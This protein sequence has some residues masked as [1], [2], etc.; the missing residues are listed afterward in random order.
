MISN[1]TFEYLPLDIPPVATVNGQRPANR[2]AT[3]EE[4]NAVRARRGYTLDPGM[5]C[6]VTWEMFSSEFGTFQY[7]WEYGLLNGLKWFWMRLPSP[8]G[9]EAWCLVRF[10]DA[11]EMVPAGWD[12]N[13]VTARLELRDRFVRATRPYTVPAP[14]T[15][16]NLDDDPLWANVAFA[17]PFETATQLDDVKNGFTP[18]TV[19]GTVGLADG[20]GE[21]PARHA[22]VHGDEAFIDYGWHDAYDLRGAAG[23]CIECLFQN[24][25]GEKDSVIWC[26]N[27]TSSEPD[28]DPYAS[29]Y[30]LAVRRR[31]LY[32]Y[33][34]DGIAQANMFEALLEDALVPGDGWYHCFVQVRKGFIEIGV[35]PLG[36]V[37]GTVYTLAPMLFGLPIQPRFVV[38]KDDAE[39]QYHKMRYFTGKVED[40]RI[41]TVVRYG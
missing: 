38:G 10:V 21:E 6:E 40:L 27:T 5:T 9:L 18:E 30:G 28:V 26:M 35:A 4:E 37:T 15:V 22:Y 3:T 41:T 31:Q 2:A 17:A 20:I 25:G 7:W 24:R 16:A 12:Q 14:F 36:S 8:D 29:N 23:Y 33:A 13:T 39:F 34:D 11:Y 19:G 32:F 1:N